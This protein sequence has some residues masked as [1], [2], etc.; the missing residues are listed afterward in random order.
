[1]LGLIGLAIVGTSIFLWFWLIQ[2]VA[3]P[4]SRAPYMVGFVGGT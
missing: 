3:V 4:R 2:Q 1:M